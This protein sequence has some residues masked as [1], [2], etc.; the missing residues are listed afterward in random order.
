MTTGS[1]FDAATTAGLGQALDVLRGRDPVLVGGLAVM[2]RVT[3]AYRATHDLDFVFDAP[4]GRDA[5]VAAL[6]HEGAASDSADAPQRLR[7]GTATVDIIDT[8]PLPAAIDDLP[9]DEGSRLFVCA[10]RFAWQTGTPIVLAGP[11]SP[12]TCR[13]ATASA[14]VVCKAHALA[15]GRR[16]RRAQKRAS[17][18]GD[19]YRLASVVLADEAEVLALRSAPWALAAQ[20]VRALASDLLGDAA[21]STAAQLR[22]GGH[23]SGDVADGEAIAPLVA[24]VARLDG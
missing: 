13:V 22:R 19:L 12:L 14:L 6:V 16:Q 8:A 5:L 23:V 4:E 21:S 18:L 7:V 24:L 3:D 15:F 9:D 11:P 17:D 2:L 10:H 20:C 1:V